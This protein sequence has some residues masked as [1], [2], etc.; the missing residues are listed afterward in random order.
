MAG[1]AAARGQDALGGMHAVDVLRAGLD[2]HQ[3]DLAARLLAA[4]A[5]SEEKTISPAAAPGEA[6]RPVA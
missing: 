5:S 1:H 6:G 4:S 3:D 2:A